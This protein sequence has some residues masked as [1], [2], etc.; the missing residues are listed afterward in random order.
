MI[1]SVADTEMCLAQ[2]DP[3]YFITDRS[4]NVQDCGD[5]IFLNDG[6]ELFFIEFKG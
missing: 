3:E 1:K 6:R 5:T 2:Q 4:L